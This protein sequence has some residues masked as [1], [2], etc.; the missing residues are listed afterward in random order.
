MSGVGDCLLLDFRRGFF[1]ISDS[2]DRNSSASRFL[3]MQYTGL[4]DGFPALKSSEVH[5]A[6]QVDHIKNDLVKRSEKLLQSLSFS[7][8]CTLTGFLILQTLEGTKG[9]LMHTGDSLLLAYHP[10][11]GG[12]RQITKSNFWMVGR[13][14][15]FYQVETLNIEKG[16]SFILA[17]DGFSGLDAPKGKERNN[18]F[19]DLFDS[20]PIEEIPDILIDRFD[21]PHP[22]KDDLGLII[23][24]P[25]GLPFD[26]PWVVFGGTTSSDE[27]KYREETRAGLYQDLYRPPDHLCEPVF[28]LQNL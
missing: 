6:Q 20:Q 12:L 17:T 9:I 22:G 11:N 16:T 15:R 18:F 25:H 14:Q 4:L 8:S 7:D 2:S 1:A 23:F 13:T 26:H 27:K 24:D 10:E 19:H 21:T 28:C 3:L 5:T